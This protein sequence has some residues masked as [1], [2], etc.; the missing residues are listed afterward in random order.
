MSTTESRSIG[1]ARWAYF[2]KNP[3]LGSPQ[4]RV[5]APKLQ[6]VD[7]EAQEQRA[8]LFAK[9]ATQFAVPST[10]LVERPGVRIT[11]DGKHIVIDLPQLTLTIETK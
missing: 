6:V 9:A 4:G 1:S 8:A 3:K 5:M 11:D 7:L 2:W 10:P